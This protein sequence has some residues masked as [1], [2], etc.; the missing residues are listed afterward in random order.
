MGHHEAAGHQRHV[1]GSRAA[2]NHAPATAFSAAVTTSTRS[3]HIS[4]TM[5][6]SAGVSTQYHCWFYNC[7][8]RGLGQE[9]SVISSAEKSAAAM[10]RVMPNIGGLP[11]SIFE[12]YSSDNWD[13]SMDKLVEKKYAQYREGDGQFE[14][15]RRDWTDGKQ[16]GRRMN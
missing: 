3:L 11:D 6:S 10:S 16:C 2:G 14:L 7:V 13:P 1:A 9:H 5:I 4:D 15:G 8:F 12:S